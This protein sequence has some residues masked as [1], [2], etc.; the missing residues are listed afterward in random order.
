MKVMKNIVALGIVIALFSCKK[1]NLKSSCPCI[2]G[3]CETKFTIENGT[4]D[5][6]GYT[7]IKW[8][9]ANYFTVKGELAELSPEYIVNNVP[10]I[11]TTFDSDYWVVFDT[12]KYTTSMYSPLGWYTDKQF[13]NPISVGN[14]TYTLK[15]IAQVQ[16]P[17]NIT[18]YQINPNT[19]FDC[20][21]SS[22]LFG[23]YSKYTYS[24]KHNYFL[25]KY[26]KGD[27]AGVFIKVVYNSDIGPRTEKIVNFKIIFE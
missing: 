18:G 5:N 2:D 16:P 11:E 12:I 25:S 8:N 14:H 17:I 23:S 9:G 4:T 3:T 21:Y 10:L 26:M 20:P 6:N 7:H 13:N 27:T 24:P 19:C 15:T 1:E 22:T